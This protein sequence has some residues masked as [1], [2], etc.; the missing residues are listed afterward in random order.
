MRLQKQ[1]SKTIV[2]VTHDFME[3]LKLADN[4]C[5]MKD[6][7][8]VQIG[9][10][11]Q[12]VLNPANDYVRDF[13]GNVPLANVLRARDVMGPVAAGSGAPQVAEEAVLE[14]AIKLFDEQTEVVDVIDA[15]GTVIGALHPL[16][17]IR[18]LYH[19]TPVPAA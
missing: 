17:V 4:I 3:A 9:T 16:K 19:D 8:I 14:E 13:V 1:L 15:T 12:I 7:E 11:A 2:F 18:G 6:G 5:L 10:P